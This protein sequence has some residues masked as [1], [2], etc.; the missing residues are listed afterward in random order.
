MTTIAYARGILAFDSR[1][2]RGG[3]KDMT[4]IKGHASKHFMA[5][6]CGLVSDVARFLDWMKMCSDEGRLMFDKESK[7]RFGLETLTD[8]SGI[9]IPKK[10][11]PIVM[12][13]TFYPI[14]FEDRYFA[15]G[16]GAAYAKAVLAIG[17]G[18]ETAVAIACQFDPYSGHPIR[19]FCK[20]DMR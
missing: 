2:S 6:G 8:F 3:E 15:L 11:K 1:V 19:R 20:K 13:E 4:M 17:H 18:A 10:G 14:E 7:E 12:D 16:S 5:A 9:I